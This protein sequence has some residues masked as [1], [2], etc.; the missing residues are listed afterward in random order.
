MKPT[1]E[2]LTDESGTEW[3]VFSACKLSIDAN[4]LNFKFTSE[5]YPINFPEDKRLGF[6]SGRKTLNFKEEH[7]LNIKFISCDITINDFPQLPFEK[8]IFDRC[9]N[10]TGSFRSKVNTQEVSIEKPCNGKF[11]ILSHRFEIEGNFSVK[12]SQSK[13]VCNEGKTIK[14]NT[15]GRTDISGA[16]HSISVESN[17]SFDDNFFAEEVK[18]G[19]S[20]ELTG[21]KSEKGGMLG[22]FGVIDNIDA[23]TIQLISQ[24]NVLIIK[25]GI[26]G[27]NVINTNFFNTTIYVNGNSA[28]N[29]GEGKFTSISSSWNP[30]KI[31]YRGF[32][33]DMKE[34]Q[35]IK[36]DIN[37]LS[38]QEFFCEMKTKFT[39]K[40][41]NILASEFYSAEMKAYRAYLKKI[42]ERGKDRIIL[43]FS[44]HSSNFGQDWLLALKWYLGIGFFVAW[45]LFCFG[46]PSCHFEFVKLLANI[47]SP[48]SIDLDKAVSGLRF[49]EWWL[50]QLFV[51]VFW[52]LWKI[53]A[54]YLIYQI[55]GS[56]RRFIRKW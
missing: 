53:T 37:P 38:A 55:I 26:Y 21:V 2:L 56:T 7:G 44:Y 18:I 49:S 48:L 35:Y 17:I 12:I 31:H 24:L 23:L 36:D 20:I 4:A 32:Y 50:W 16:C 41:D 11:S 22:F 51:W 43:F 27:L 40:G 29:L 42:H 46:A 52:M 3:I 15:D 30:L 34:E 1:V 33:P 6:N 9:E 25:E 54:G 5:E 10:I 8:I 13:I 45:T 47:Y 14:G 28:I 19:R 39:K